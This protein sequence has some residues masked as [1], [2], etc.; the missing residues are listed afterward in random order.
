M[1]LAAGG[2]ILQVAPFALVRKGPLGGPAGAALARRV[3]TWRRATGDAG[4]AIV[5]LVDLEGVAAERPT[6]VSVADERASDAETLSAN[7]S[8]AEAEEE[9]EA[10]Q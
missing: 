3:A 6:G 10:S 5:Y 4:D 2:Q 7:A 9:R 8:S 1:G